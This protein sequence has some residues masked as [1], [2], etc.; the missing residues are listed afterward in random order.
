[1]IERCDGY[2]H[3]F[4]KGAMVCYCGKIDRR[5]KMMQ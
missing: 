5:K 3:Y 1:M 2:K 4:A